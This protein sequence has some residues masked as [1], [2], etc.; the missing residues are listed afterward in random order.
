MVVLDNPHLSRSRSRLRVV[1]VLGAEAAV[2]LVVKAVKNR[3]L[4]RCL[5]VS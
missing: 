5:I 4:T 1:E 3:V 2:V